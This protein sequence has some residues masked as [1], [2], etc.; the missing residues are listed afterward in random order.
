MIIPELQF[1]EIQREA[2]LG[3]TVVFHQPLLG[4]TPKSLE[5]VD[6]DPTGGEVLLVVYLQVPVA[7]EHEA[8]IAAELIRID[9]TAP[10][11][12]LDGERKQRSGRDIRHNR[13]MNPA[14]PLQDAEH[15]HFPG[16][17][18][19]SFAFAPAPEVGLVEFDLAAQQRGGIL[20]VA[21]DGH[22]DCGDGPIDAPIG[23]TQLQGHLADRDIQFKE[24]DQ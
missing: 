9:H 1:F 13:D 17:S 10:A 14:C 5:A 3:D 19:A 12:L 24:L 21:Q 20:S 4:P 11:N 16:R 18:L 22:S 6:V 23:Q 7:A 2:V 8:V 15:R